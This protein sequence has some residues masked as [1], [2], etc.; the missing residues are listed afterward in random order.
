MTT[1]YVNPGESIQSAI[2]SANAGDD[3]IVRA[4]TYIGGVTLNK[5]VLL[6]GE[7]GAVL[8]PS[9]AGSGTGVT[10]A[11]DGAVVESLTLDSF[12]CGI[13]PA[14]I[15][16]M[17]GFKNDVGVTNC[18]VFRAQYSCWIGGKRW[19]VRDNEFA[20]PRW[21][22]GQ[23]DCDYTRMFGSYHVFAN[24]WL[25]G[26]NFSDTSLAP[27]SGSDYAHC[28][29]IQYYGSN[30]EVFQDILIVDNL[31]EDFL[32]GMFICDE[33]NTSA[34]A[35]VMIRNNRFISKNYTPAP[36][37]AN[38]SGR[39]S[40]GVCIGKN[41]G[42]TDIVLENNTLVNIN[43]AV[44]LRGAV[45]G[46]MFMNVLRNYGNGTAYDPSCTTPSKVSNSNLVYG[47]AAFGQ[48][49]NGADT[50]KDPVLDANYYA[51]AAPGYGY[52]PATAP[53]PTPPPDPTPTP[54]PTPEYVTHDEFAAAQTADDAR[55]DAIEARLTALETR[56]N[57]Q[58]KTRMALRGY[59]GRKYYGR[60][61]P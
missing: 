18:K 53:A 32:Q 14:S 19:F 33:P 10:I 35:R 25:H 56:M 27:A 7:A 38:Y 59:D 30:G 28:D 34:I 1:R 5:A 54:E 6:A 4:G 22:N 37:S 41:Y 39:A 40:W 61:E 24:N 45:N 51:T 11:A 57:A 20:F 8:K 26:A 13:G 31:I 9:T 58:P 50:V 16:S 47:F 29:G 2:N 52:Q 21:W 48:A 49:W 12:N 60:V 43:N 17:S 42:A 55:M 23:G 46:A 44:G 3:I 36:G 15:G